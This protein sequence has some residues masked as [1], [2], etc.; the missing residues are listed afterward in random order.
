MSEF[1]CRN[2][3]MMT[4]LRCDICGEYLNMGGC[5]IVNPKLNMTFPDP[6][7]PLEDWYLPELAIHYMRHGSFDCFGEIH[8]GRVDIPRLLRVLE[9]PYPYIPDKHQLTLDSNDVDGDF[10]T[11]SEE[12][13]AGY[14]PQDADQDDNI[15]PDGVD[16]AQ[17]CLEVIR[18]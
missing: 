7:D 5:E 15:T 11:D 4:G 17:Q 12:L 2:G 16:L 18:C 13:A 6:N 1:E 3:H 8:N 9:M 14:N 10:L